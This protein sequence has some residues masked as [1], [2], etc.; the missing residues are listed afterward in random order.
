MELFLKLSGIL[1]GVLARTMI[2]Y[3][4][5]IMAGKIK[6]FDKEYWL[7][8]LASFVLSLIT[9]LLIFPKFEFVPAGAGVETWIRLF[10]AAFG[11]GF[12]WNSIVNEGIKWGEKRK[13]EK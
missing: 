7:T 5:K 9:T 4:R 10:C 11:F 6:K 12:A 3:L 2:P 13:I 1:L 8:A